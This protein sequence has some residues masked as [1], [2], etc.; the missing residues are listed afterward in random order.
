MDSAVFNDL[1]KIVAPIISEK[2]TVMWE[3]IRAS[4]RW[5]V[6]LLSGHRQRT[7]RHEI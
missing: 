6:A 2:N 3:G 7:G 4:T 5:S 1:L